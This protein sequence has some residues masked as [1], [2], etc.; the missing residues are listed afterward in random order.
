[1]HMLPTTYSI[2]SSARA[3]SDGGTVTPMALAVI[4][5]M[6]SSNLIGCSTGISAGLIPCKICAH[7]L[8]LYGRARQ[9]S[10]HMP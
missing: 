2:T 8:R 7:D 4:R 10:C 9:S 1:M 6:I 5:L 3:S